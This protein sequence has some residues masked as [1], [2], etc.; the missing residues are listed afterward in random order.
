MRGSSRTGRRQPAV[1]G[2]VLAL[3]AALW[4]WT[5]VLTPSD[6]GAACRPGGADPS[7][8]RVPASL[9]RSYQWGEWRSFPPGRVC[10]VY[11]YDPKLLL[12]RGT[13]PGGPDSKLVAEKTYP[14]GAEYGWVALAFA[15]PFLL[16][17]A[18]RRVR[19]R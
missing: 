17:S 16:V 5:P 9:G 6:V 11:A 7:R 19:A 14:E 1:V 12:E 18:Y 8:G 13:F 4:I 2:S 15:A 10:Q 3:F